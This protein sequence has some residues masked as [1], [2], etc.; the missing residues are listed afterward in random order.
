VP[1]ARV[2]GAI[3]LLKS[4]ALHC[5]IIA[6]FIG[7]QAVGASAFASQLTR[8]AQPDGGRH[9][10]PNLNV[11]YSFAGGADGALPAASLILDQFGSL[12]G[13]TQ[14]GGTANM[15]TVFSLTPS[16]QGYS[17]SVLHAFS[18]GRSDGALPTAALLNGASGVVYGTTVEGGFDSSQRGCRNA[19]YQGCGTIFELVPSGSTYAEH[20]IYA[21]PGDEKGAGVFPFAALTAGVDGAL[22]GATLWGGEGLGNVFRLV[23]RGTN[24]HETVVF[25]FPFGSSGPSFAP[26]GFNPAASLISDKSGNLYGVAEAG[27]TCSSQ[28]AVGCGVAF[29]LMPSAS[30]Y[31]F[32]TLHIFQGGS[33][34]DGPL[35]ALVRGG[36]GSLYG[37]T[38]YGGPD[39]RG[40]VFSLSQSGSGYAENVVYAFKGGRDG[41]LPLAGLILGKNGSFYGTTSAGGPANLGTV[42][43]LVR[44]GSGYSE[45]VL[46]TFKGGNDGAEPAAALFASST[47][48]LYGTTVAGGASG[49]GT[50]FSLER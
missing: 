32:T 31:I 20:M 22:Y 48:V 38:E 26:E 3:Q 39:N 17:E 43:Q 5:S 16:G 47:N 23:Q 6:F 33:D 44:D 13:T 14:A 35:G 10:M 34:G 50:V 36:D 46:H 4:P 27:G 12:L 1:K 28:P 15:G 24:Y 18:G 37:T 45:R 25:S 7:S 42:F 8:S 9:A 40:T 29:E 21:F 49:L 41:A 11:I 19:Q 2:L 30:G